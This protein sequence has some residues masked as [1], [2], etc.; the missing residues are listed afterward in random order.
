V[1]ESQ[2]KPRVKVIY[3]DTG[4]THVAFGVRTFSLFDKKQRPVMRVL[5]TIL[6]GGMSSRLFTKM[7][8]ELGICYYVRAGQNSMTD[9]GY[10]GISAGVDTDRVD[11]G[12]KTILE[13]VNKLKTELVTVEELRR[14]KDLISGS[15]ML[16]LET[17]DAR[18]DYAAHQEI[19]TKEIRKPEDALKEIRRVTA[20]QIRD[21][22]RKYFVDTSLNMAIIGPYKESK[23]FED[24]LTFGK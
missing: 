16:G 6:G 18:A 23:R 11:I 20:K 22:A 4:Q 15:S 24:I 21:L 10:F 14:A 13:E 8:D 5:G 7:R 17:S 12:L 3:K 9:H 1:T 2:D 19:L